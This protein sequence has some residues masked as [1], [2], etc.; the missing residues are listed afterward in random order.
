MTFDNYGMEAGFE[1]KAFAEDF[2]RSENVSF[3]TFMGSGNNWY[4][5]SDTLTAARLV[6]AYLA[7]AEHVMTYGSSMGGYA[8]LRLAHPI[9]ATACLSLSPQF[10]NDPRKAR[11]EQ[12]WRQEGQATRWLKGIDG[13][14]RASFRPV[15]AYD[16]TDLDG[17]HV[18]LIAR[19]IPITSLPIRYAGHPVS[20]Y[21]SMSRALRP[22]VF[23]VLDGSLDAEAFLAEL[24]SSTKL[25]PFYLSELAKRQPAHRAR[26][27]IRLARRAVELAPGDELML[28]VL[29]GRLTAAE[30]HEE[31]LELHARAVVQSGGF[32]GYALPYSEALYAGG[33]ANESLAVARQITADHPDYAQLHHWLSVISWKTGYRAEALRH[34]RIAKQLN[35]VN[36]AY[37]RFYNFV[38]RESGSGGIARLQ[39]AWHRLRRTPFPV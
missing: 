30:Q 38:R 6:R 32:I 18:A 21:L 4:Q 12:R 13:V 31:A 25:N 23:A 2:L 35:P 1:R 34:A 39:R 7:G 3:V 15:I 22:L 36:K 24:R 5:Y 26:L 17:R 8:A 11:F 19:E 20:T 28:H 14:L 37:T 29:A 33:R 27:A 16:P 10:S 9:G